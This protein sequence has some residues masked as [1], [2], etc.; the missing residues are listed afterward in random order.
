MGRK[1]PNNTAIHDEPPNTDLTAIVDFGALTEV[2]RPIQEDD[3]NKIAVRRGKVRSLMQMGYGASEIYQI[4]QK[5]I[6]INGVMV[7]I[8]MTE[9]AIKNDIEYIRQED[10]AVDIELPEKRAEILDKLKF[11]YKQAIKEYLAAK[12]SVK[13]SFLNTA[14]TIMNKISDI[15]GVN[16]PDAINFNVNDES[17][18]AKYATEIQSLGEE[19]RNVL[20]TAIRQVLGK[21]QQ[22]S[23][24]NDGVPSEPS[25][26]PTQTSDDEGIP[27]E[28]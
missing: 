14:L 26:I 24:G 4:L 15:E 10:A 18:I 3:I 25:A 20:V 9:S 11:L 7:S 13:N 12:G 17:K 5:G 23:T 1:N 19:D 2:P 16:S 22:E 28:S 27:R 21:R 6:K 8:P